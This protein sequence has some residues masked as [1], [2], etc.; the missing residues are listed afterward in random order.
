VA[1]KQMRVTGSNLKNFMA[2]IN[3]QKKTEHPNVVQLFDSYHL[4]DHLWVVLEYMEG[5]NLYQV[6]NEVKRANV[7]FQESAI[8]YICCETLKAL[9]YIHSQ[10]RIHRDIK[11]DNILIGGN[12]EI[13]LADFGY[14]VQLESAEE[15]RSTVCGSPY[16]MAPEVIR[17]EEYGKEVDIW[18]LGIM[19][20]ECCDL[21]PPYFAEQPSKALLLIATKPPP[22]LK[23]PEKWSSKLKQFLS[24]CLQ[25]EGSKRPR[26]IEL[27]QHAFIASLCSAKEF[28]QY[29]KFLE[30]QEIQTPEKEETSNLNQEQTPAKEQMK[31]KKDPCLVQ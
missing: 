26:A 17:G 31:K 3:I 23:A 28:K 20:L 7:Q 13:K 1:I 8:G 11:S 2:E 4:D 5:G 9:S 6:L 12:G 16:W 15:K 27:L 21:E 19:T 22:T 25:E 14:A 29:I 24:L 10:H 30:D 18:S